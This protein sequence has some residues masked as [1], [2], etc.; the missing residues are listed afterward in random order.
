MSPH[1]KEE[2]VP[3]GPASPRGLCPQGSWFLGLQQCGAAAAGTRKA[4]GGS[5]GPGGAG[6]DEG[7]LRAAVRSQVRGADDALHAEAG[8]GS[9]AGRE[10]PDC[11]GPLHSA[12]RGWGRGMRGRSPGGKGSWRVMPDSGRPDP[13]LAGTS[14]HPPRQRLRSGLTLAAGPPRETPLSPWPQAG[15]RS[16]PPLCSGAR[17]WPDP[18]PNSLEASCHPPKRV[19]NSE[20]NFNSSSHGSTSYGHSRTILNSVREQGPARC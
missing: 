9:R 11:L 19:F 4:S 16:P 7:P 3:P 10:L 8:T 6:G 5:G 18:A 13:G 17:R 1:P 2:K 12:L 15:H 20:F 14:R